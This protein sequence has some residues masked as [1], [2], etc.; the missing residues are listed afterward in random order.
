MCHV[1]DYFF[2]LSQTLV[3]LLGSR[4]KTLKHSGTTQVSEGAG[5][6]DRREEGGRKDEERRKK[7]ESGEEEEKAL[8]IFC[9][10]FFLQ[11]WDVRIPFSEL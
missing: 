5:E 1:T 8:D 2:F 6:G 9:Y 10:L 7:E 3:S 4:M 11:R